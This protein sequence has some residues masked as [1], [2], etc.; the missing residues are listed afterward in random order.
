MIKEAVILAAGLGSRPGER[1][2]GMP[3][4]GDEK[5]RIIDI[6]LQSALPYNY[7]YRS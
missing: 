5:R 3:E 7:G 6:I 4:T 1:T 2:A